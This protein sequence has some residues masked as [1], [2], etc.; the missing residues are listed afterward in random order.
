MKQPRMPTDTRKERQQASCHEAR[1]RRRPGSKESFAWQTT[2]RTP[3][4]DQPLR[5]LTD[6]K[7]LHNFGSYSTGTLPSIPADGKSD[8]INWVIGCQQS[9]TGNPW[10]PAMAPR[11]AGEMAYFCPKAL[12]MASV[13][14]L[15]SVLSPPDQAHMLR[16]TSVIRIPDIHISNRIPSR[17][18]T[19]NRL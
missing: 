5:I 8:S 6:A 4:R 9:D 16:T 3:F 12:R 2:S 14:P 7:A 19:C 17:L 10:S 1:G 13:K 11:T 18:K 15:V